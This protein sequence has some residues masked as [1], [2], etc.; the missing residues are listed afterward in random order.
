MLSYASLRHFCGLTLAALSLALSAA[1]HA[2]TGYTIIDLGTL[3]GP[4]SYA[5]GINAG[6]QAAGS[7]DTANS[8]GIHAVR[9]TGTLAADLG[10]LGGGGSSGYGINDSGQVTGYAYLTGD[11][12]HHAVRWT[13]ATAQ[14]LGTLGGANSTAYGINNSGQ[15]AGSAQLT[16]NAASHAV[17]WTGTTPADLGTLGGSSSTGEGINASGQ[18]AG[19]ASLKGDTVS[20][21]VRW[22]GTTAQDLGTLG[23]AESTGFGINA[24]GQVAGYAN[25]AGDTAFHA[26]LW[27][28]TTAADLGTLGGTNSRGFGINTIGEVVGSSDTAGGDTAAFLYTSGRLIDLNTLLPAESG[29]QLA[30]ARG[31]NDSGW[32]IGSGTLNGQAH[33]YLLKPVAS[34]GTSRIALEGVPDLSKIS[35]AAPLGRFYITLRTHGTTTALFARD[36]TLTPIAGSA[37]GTYTLAGIPNG[38][39]DITIKGSKSVRV[40]LPNILINGAA[41]VPDVTLPGG[42]ANGDNQVDVGDFGLL[43]NAYGAA[44]G[45]STGLYDPR[46]DFNYNGLVDVTDFGLLVNAYGTVGDL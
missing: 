42:N 19:Y 33:A 11:I 5:F 18:V 36:V 34:T 39:Y 40:L 16:G 9:W 46:A 1:S 22:T 32:I 27:T 41:S 23:G 44:A 28:G 7:A 2:Q 4:K 30:A 20:H 17:R 24:G 14:D 21:A 45:D 37:F 29:W 13:G 35:P 6:G 38:T 25:L 15:V 26:A 43:L 8:A 3:G 10:T 12:V 31:I